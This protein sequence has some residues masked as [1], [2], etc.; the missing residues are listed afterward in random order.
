[1]NLT[2]KAGAHALV[3]GKKSF[4]T[5]L[6]YLYYI[7]LSILILIRK[8]FCFNSLNH[9][10]GFHRIIEY[11]LKCK[12]LFFY[13]EEDKIT[14]HKFLVDFYNKLSNKNKK[15]IKFKNSPHVSHFQFYKDDYFNEIKNFLN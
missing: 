8:F 2:P 3:E 7:L 11:D 6:F 5:V 12:Y 13:S 10:V 4:K 1:V 15:I 9:E 14:D